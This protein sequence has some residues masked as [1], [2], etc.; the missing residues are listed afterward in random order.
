MKSFDTITDPVYVKPKFS[1]LDR[2]FLKFIRD[3]RDLPFVYFTLLI[4]FTLIP[5]AVLMYI[6]GVPSWL[7]WS[8]A[9]I[10][11]ILNNGIF[12]GPFLLMMH[13]TSHRPFFTKEYGFL[14]HYHPWVIGPFF[15]QS[16]ET[17]YTHHL[18]MHHAENN[19]PDDESC[20]MPFNRDSIGGFL[21]YFSVFLFTGIYHLSMYFVRK[22][23]KKLLYRSLRGE[24]L[25]IAMCVGL[26]FI[27]WPATLVVFISPF[28]ISRIVMM[29]GNWVQHAFI[30]PN[31]P[32]NSYK[33]SLSCINTIYNRQ[34]W[35]DGYHIAHHEKPAMHY[36]EYPIYFKETIDEY[37]KNDAVVFDGIHYLH[38][39]AYLM[40]KRYDL[41]AKHFVNIGNRFKSDEEVIAFLKSRTRRFPKAE[42]I[43]FTPV[44]G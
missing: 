4:T 36:T 14:N 16:P 24:L 22:R 35:N 21:T 8:A 32:G 38:I 42:M 23:R 12:K 13:C 15:G 29:L 33:N 28:L 31:D 44:Y 2:Y 5:L 19:L 34:C 30:D 37:I 10:Y 41:L 6:P 27:N 1:A 39:F 11:F 40:T 43:K 3:E 7:W 20:T 9:A 25:F 18:G 17:Y 26:C